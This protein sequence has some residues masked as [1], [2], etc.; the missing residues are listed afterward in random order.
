[1]Y[2]YST[3]L[4]LKIVYGDEIKPNTVQLTISCKNN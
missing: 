3:Y 4:V 2:N 1:M